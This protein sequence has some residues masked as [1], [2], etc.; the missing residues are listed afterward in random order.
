MQEKAK[1]ISELEAQATASRDRS[2]QKMTQMEKQLATARSIEGE[3]K[4]E[5]FKLKQKL[6]EKSLIQSQES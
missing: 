1:K 4:N 6:D 5:V 2:E 3:L